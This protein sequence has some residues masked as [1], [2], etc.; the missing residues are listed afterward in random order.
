VN[1]PNL[2]GAETRKL[3]RVGKAV[4]ELLDQIG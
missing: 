3:E 2:T 4:E 1:S